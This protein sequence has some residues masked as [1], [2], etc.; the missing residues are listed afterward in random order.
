MLRIRDPKASL[1]F[2]TR[3]LGMTLLERLDFKDMAFSLYFLAYVD[4][5]K[6]PEDRK[7]RVQ[8]MFAQPGCLELTHNW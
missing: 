2:Y 8:W 4:P 7:E 3:A 1:E 5:S 6:I